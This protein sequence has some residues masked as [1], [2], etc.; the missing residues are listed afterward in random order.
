MAVLRARTL[1][2]GKF[3][4]QQLWTGG[5]AGDKGSTC[6]SPL[7]RAPAA[8]CAAD[9]ARLCAPGAPP[10]TEALMYA[11]SPGGC[12]GNPAALVNAANDIAN[13]LLIRGASAYIGHGWL[14]CS[15]T[16]E[17]PELLNT[18][19]GAPLGLC[20]QTSPGV[21]ARNYSKVAVEMDCN[22][23]ASK[24]VARG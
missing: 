22:T 12:S 17:F 23:G 15:K 2:A 3:A 6:P 5:A 11:F 4:W 10:A 9:L 8:E 18:D 1:A 16:Y 21:F 19:V 14:A 13:F 20:A 7:V 24:I